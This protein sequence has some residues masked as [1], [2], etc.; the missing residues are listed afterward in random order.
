[1]MKITSIFFFRT[2]VDENEAIERTSVP[3]A[4]VSFFDDSTKNNWVYA[5]ET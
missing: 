1:M 5:S 2:V 3:D 4:R